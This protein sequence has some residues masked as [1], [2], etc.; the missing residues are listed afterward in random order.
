MEARAAWRAGRHTRL[1][2]PSGRCSGIRQSATLRGLKDEAR[3]SLDSAVGYLA[4]LTSC[5]DYGS[6][7][8]AG[9]PIATGVIE[10]ACRYLVQDRMGITGARWGLPGG[11]A[12]LAVRAVDLCGDWDDFWQFHLE[13]EHGR[14]EAPQNKVYYSIA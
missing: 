13:R 5:L 3:K 8:K 4:K 6:Y 10:G 11:E 12:V 2:H 9:M 1:S 7:L 14:K